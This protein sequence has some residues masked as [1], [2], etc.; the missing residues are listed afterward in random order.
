MQWRSSSARISHMMPIG[1]RTRR[2]VRRRESR[3]RPAKDGESK[4]SRW[5]T[6]GALDALERMQKSDDPRI[7]RTDEWKSTMR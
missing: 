4:S 7:P 1:Q 2:T 3:V 6:H 5:K